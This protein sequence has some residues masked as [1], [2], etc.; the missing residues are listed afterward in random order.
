YEI[1]ADPARAD[2]AFEIS[3][4]NDRTCKMRENYR[5]IVLISDAH[6]HH[7]RTRLVEPAQILRLTDDFDQI[8]D[9]AIANLIGDVAKEVGSPAPIKPQLT[10]SR[11]ILPVPPLMDAAHKVFVESTVD[12]ENPGNRFVAD[13]NQLLND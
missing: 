3:I 10:Q 5:I 1:V 6:T 7:V 9:R 13:A 12:A 11:L 2:W 8:F 4:T